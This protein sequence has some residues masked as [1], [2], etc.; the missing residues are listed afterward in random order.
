MEDYHNYSSF[1]YL[2][3]DVMYAQLRQFAEYVCKALPKG[4]EG[5]Q[6]ITAQVKKMKARK[7]R[8]PDKVM[9]T[10]LQRIIPLFT[11]ESILKLIQAYFS[12]GEEVNEHRKRQR[13]ALKTDINRKKKIIDDIN[14][15]RLAQQDSYNTLLLTS[16]ADMGWFP[17]HSVEYTHM[18]KKT[19]CLVCCIPDCTTEINDS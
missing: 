7:Q 1:N 16:Q 3:E 13:E 8:W 6:A 19:R 4:A 12:W 10:W 14:Q 11:T 2:S 15:K 9:I 5:T 17:A 18:E